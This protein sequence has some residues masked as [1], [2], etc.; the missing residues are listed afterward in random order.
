ML[1]TTRKNCRPSWR[2][3]GEI[4]SKE[5]L[6]IVPCIDSALGRFSA[7]GELINTLHAR[8]L[9]T[10]ARKNPATVFG[11][12]T[13][14]KA[15]I[16]KL[17]RTFPELFPN[18]VIMIYSNPRMDKRIME[19]PYGF[20]KVFNVQKTDAGVNCGAKLCR[21]CR[22]CYTKDNGINIIVEKLK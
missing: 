9:L 19:V 20:D 18:N 22:Q 8:N 2:N 5:P 1:R 13:K 21:D 12:W 15:I 6:A 4:L 14:R 16:Q 10:I 7:H 3:N 17:K 11:F